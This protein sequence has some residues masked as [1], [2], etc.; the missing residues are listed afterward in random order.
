MHCALVLILCCTI[1]AYMEGRIDLR[2]T[3]K[4]VIAV[5]PPRR[6]KLLEEILSR[7]LGEL[8]ADDTVLLRAESLEDAVAM[9]IE[10]GVREDELAVEGKSVGFKAEVTRKHGVL[11][12]PNC[13]SPDLERIGI[14]GLT[15]T[16]Y[17]C[18]KCGFATYL[19]LEVLPE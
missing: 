6:G 19:P 14:P 11:V 9:L 5:L 3:E 2:I 12:C 1:T 18:R 13:G 17:V 10:L 8:L 4:G 7:G 16:L 15:P